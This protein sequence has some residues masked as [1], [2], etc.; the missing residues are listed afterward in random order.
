MRTGDGACG[1]HRFHV[2]LSTQAAYGRVTLLRKS[3][4]ALPLLF[5]EESCQPAGKTSGSSGRRRSSVTKWT[6]RFNRAA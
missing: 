4:D 5:T 6:S 2:A 1:L 3:S